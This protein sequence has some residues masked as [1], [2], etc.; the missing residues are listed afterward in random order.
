[1]PSLAEIG[2]VILEAKIFKLR[3]GIFAISFLS[4]LGKGRGPL[5]K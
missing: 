5:F 2:S 4:H 3:S 1:M